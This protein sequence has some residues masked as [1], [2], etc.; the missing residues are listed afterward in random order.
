MTW[1]YLFIAYMIIAGV[2][3]WVYCKWVKWPV[4]KEQQERFTRLNA[5][6]FKLKNEIRINGTK[7]LL[8]G[9]NKNG[10]N[11]ISGQAKGNGAA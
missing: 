5:D 10:K 6:I 3:T 11:F 1:L 8:N 4:D 2:S 9:K 7:Q